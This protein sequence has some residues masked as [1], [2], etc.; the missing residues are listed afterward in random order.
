MA[1][2]IPNFGMMF[3][4]HLFS[5]G[6]LFMAHSLLTI[7]WKACGQYFKAMWLVFFNF[8]QIIGKFIVVQPSVELYSANISQLLP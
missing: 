2:P 3:F 1:G 4:V 8:S 5:K 6:K 7:T